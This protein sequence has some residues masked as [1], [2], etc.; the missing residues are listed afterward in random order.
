[1]VNRYQFNK[2]YSQMKQEFGMVPHGGEGNYA[3]ILFPMEG[4]VLKIHRQFP[5]SNSR[6]MDEAIALVLFDIK[7]SF[8]Y[9][10]N[11]GNSEKGG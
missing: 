6:R 5:S 3:M 4:N 10:T 2:I 11:I 7:E 9:N 1:M 8:L